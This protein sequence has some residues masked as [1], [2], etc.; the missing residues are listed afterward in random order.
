MYLH[1]EDNLVIKPFYNHVSNRQIVQTEVFSQ[2]MATKLQHFYDITIIAIQR[3]DDDIEKEKEEKNGE[4]KN[5]VNEI[6]CF[7][8]I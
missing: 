4:K 1:L 5:H 2:W 3:K 7:V 8:S 6:F